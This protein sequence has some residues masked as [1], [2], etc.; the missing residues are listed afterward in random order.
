MTQPPTHTRGRPHHLGLGYRA[1]EFVRRLWQ[2]SDDDDVFFMAGALA[3]NVLMALLPLML[4]G[5]GLT[6][7]VLSARFQDPTGA[8]VS[9]V[10]ENLPRA[11]VDLTGLLGGLVEGL[12]EQ[13]KGFTALG[14]VFFI[15]LATRLVGS[16]RTTLREIFDIGARR[17]I[18]GGKL[19]DIAA[20]IV[21]LVL[22]TL[23][24]GFT[25]ALAGVWDV[26]VRFVG[27]SGEALSL[28]EQVAGICLALVS[29]WTLFLIAYRYLPARPIKWRT[30]V[31]AAT[32]SALGHEALKLGFSWYATRV[33]D[34]GSSFGNLATVAVLFFW[35]YYG[36]LVFILGGEIAQVS[37]MRKAS[38]VG[39]VNF[40]AGS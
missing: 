35:I 37:T 15:W 34:Y 25:L 16:V 9:L 8:V 39:V 12:V 30:A 10:G 5:A 24:M 21:G 22:L 11:G 6:G 19:F 31:I 3:F 27:L 4:L 29:I 32:F 23:N 2:K 33:A 38:R 1:R 20:V 36:A 26:G 14:S 13:R 7:F 28:A 17:S 40:E 18:V